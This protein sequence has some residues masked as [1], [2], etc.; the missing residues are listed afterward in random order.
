MHS[1]VKKEDGFAL[2]GIMI[3]VLIIAAIFYGG[4]F[5]LN[6]KRANDLNTAARVKEQLEDISRKNDELNRLNK[7]ILNDERMASSTSK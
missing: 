5:F 1:F 7:E 3:S 2:I 6:K 4:S